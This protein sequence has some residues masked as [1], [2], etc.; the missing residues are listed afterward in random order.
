V[1]RN[2]RNFTQLNQ[3]ERPRS[4]KNAINDETLNNVL[5]GL[6]FYRN[7]SEKWH[8]E[9]IFWKS[10]YDK[11]RENLDNLELRF[12]EVEREVSNLKYIVNKMDGREIVRDEN[13]N[14]TGIRRV[15]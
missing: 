6:E 10:A 14:I 3:E 13:Q 12:R 2:I 8:K 4:K 7:E 9:S 5:E 1:S 11:E 15:K